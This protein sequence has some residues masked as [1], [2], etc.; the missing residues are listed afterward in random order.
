MQAKWWKACALPPAQPPPAA[1]P[2]QV[3]AKPA[4]RR[5]TPK[6]RQG[7]QGA[8]SQSAAARGAPDVR[9]G[10]KDARP[11]PP[12]P[13]RGGA[14]R[15]AQRNWPM[16]WPYSLHTMMAVRVKRRIDAARQAPEHPPDLWSAGLGIFS[17]HLGDWR[18]GL[19]HWL[20]NHPRHAA[21]HHL[22]SAGWAGRGRA[23]SGLHCLCGE[24]G[25]LRAFAWRHVGPDWA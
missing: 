9:G 3:S 7:N 2:R 11:E 13:G 19:H 5:S 14:Y 15:G 18:G 10:R 25:H 23:F 17:W 21:F 8:A 24:C 12:A 22:C 6:G 4:Q 1:N 20:F 16:L